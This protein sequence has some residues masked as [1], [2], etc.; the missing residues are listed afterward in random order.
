[1]KIACVFNG[2]IYVFPT[3]KYV[4][5]RIWEIQYVNSCLPKG[6]F[7]SLHC[8]S[9]IATL[10]N[11]QSLWAFLPMFVLPLLVYAEKSSY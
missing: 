10:A 5:L 7:E 9:G 4:E 3:K 2:N 1:M 8:R 11:E 6:S